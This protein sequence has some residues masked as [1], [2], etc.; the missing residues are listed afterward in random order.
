MHSCASLH[1]RP[2]TVALSPALPCPDQGTSSPTRLQLPV[3]PI[4][5]N[6]SQLQLGVMG[7]QGPVG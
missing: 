1:R 2:T 7:P 5:T 6:V 3:Q 4:A